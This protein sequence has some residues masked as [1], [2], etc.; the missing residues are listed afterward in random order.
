MDAAQLKHIISIALYCAVGFATICGIIRF[1]RLAYRKQKIDQS[2]VCTGRAT[3]YFKHEEKD[4]PYLGRGYSY[5][6]YVTFHTDL[7]EALKLYMNGDDFFILHE[8]DVGE[9]TWQGEKFWKFV[10][11]QSNTNS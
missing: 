3:V 5:V 9:L 1:A 8:G 6:Y 10:S 7:G 2:P 11:E 4:A